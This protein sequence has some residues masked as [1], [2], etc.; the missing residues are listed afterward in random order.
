MESSPVAQTINADQ[1]AIQT[2]QA[3]Q[4]QGNV[5]VTQAGHVQQA[6]QVFQV[7]GGQILQTAS[8]GQQIMLQLPQHQLQ[9]LQLG[10][11]AIQIPVSG[12]QV[13]QVQVI[14]PQQIQ[15][16]AGQQIQ[17]VQSQTGQPQQIIIQQQ[18]PAQ[19]GNQLAQYQQFITADGQTVLYQ[20]VQATDNSQTQILQ[21]VQQIQG[22]T[23]QIPQSVTAATPTAATTTT[24]TATN[25]SNVIT[26]PVSSTSSGGMVMMVPGAGGVQTMQRIPL[27]GAELLEEEPLY[28][29]AKQYHRILKRRQARAKLEAEGKIPKERKK[30]LH[31]S[32]HKHAMNRVRGDG[33]R[34]H[35][36]IENESADG[37]GLDV[38][39]NGSSVDTNA[40]PLHLDVSAD[41]GIMNAHVIMEHSA[42]L[43]GVPTTDGAHNG[44]H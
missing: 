11:T 37:I 28:V 23:V 5:Q 9:Q 3:A 2:I 40:L 20:P 36:L 43:V 25:S 8:G 15:V 12:S 14:Q 39:Q 38:A 7:S 1:I 34:F 41:P 18:Q 27:P 35:S 29:N 24:T 19:Q 32:R 17:Q 44:D 31:E 10:Q 21:Q 16:Q 4:Q 42:D 26:V 33:G 22:N 6:A 13:Q 30:Y